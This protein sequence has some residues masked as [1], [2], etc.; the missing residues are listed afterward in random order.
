MYKNWQS[1][2]YSSRHW[3]VTRSRI[4][5][6]AGWPDVST[7]WLVSTCSL[8]CSYG[9]AFQTLPCVSADKLTKPQ[10]TF[11]VLP[12]ICRET[13]AN[14]AT[15]CWSDDQA[16]GLSRRPLLDGWFCGIIWT[17]DLTCTS[18]DR[19]RRRKSAA[20]TSVW[21][22]LTSSKQVDPW[23]IRCNPTQQSNRGLCFL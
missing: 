16:V 15:G 2:G 9:L 5:D 17:K 22:Q 12:K 3:V 11:W 20:M 4:E 8:T 10:T 6:R 21:K 7:L 19:W 14:M 13:S 18:V 1:T 23:P